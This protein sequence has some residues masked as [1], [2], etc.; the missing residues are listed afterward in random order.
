MTTSEELVKRILIETLRGTRLE[1][2][3]LGDILREFI[4]FVW[5]FGDKVSGGLTDF[6]A[7]EPAGRNV[8]LAGKNGNSHGEIHLSN[9][10]RYNS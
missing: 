2:D 5:R 1:K 3:R 6:W 9:I 4:T 8:P 7:E 10:S